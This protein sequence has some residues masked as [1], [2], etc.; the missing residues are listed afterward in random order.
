[1][2]TAYDRRLLSAIWRGNLSHRHHPIFQLSS[3][4]TITAKTPLHSPVPYYGGSGSITALL[5]NFEYSIFDTLCDKGN[6]PEFTA[7]H[8]IPT[9]LEILQIRIGGRTGLDLQET[10]SCYQSICHL[11][12]LKIR[13]SNCQE[14]ATKEIRRTHPLHCR[15]RQLRRMRWRKMVRIH[16]R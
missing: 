16:R 2:I 14:V 6:V 7:P 13:T 4:P 9:S 15:Q 8:S 1:M 11:Q 10:S 3:N 5:N 12:P